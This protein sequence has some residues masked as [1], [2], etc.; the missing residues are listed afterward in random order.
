M[1]DAVPAGAAVAARALSQLGELV[2]EVRYLD[3]GRRA[4]EA[5]AGQIAAQPSAHAAMVSAA[6]E[7]ESPRVQVILRGDAGTIGA[8]REAIA[9]APSAPAVYAIPADAEGL[10]EG[11]AAMPAAGKAVA[12][13]CRA[14][15]CSPPLGELQVVLRNL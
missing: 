2:G 9:A 11:L 3:A 15:T 12:Y 5:F 14:G 8:W 10:P 6:M 4:V 13:V 7:L 1:D